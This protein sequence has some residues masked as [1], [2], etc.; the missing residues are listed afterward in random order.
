M[1]L[2]GP[3]K[4]KKYIYNFHWVHAGLAQSFTAVVQCTLYAVK[5]QEYVKKQTGINPWPLG[6]LQQITLC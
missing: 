6:P 1:I 2:N 3:T 4:A 5:E